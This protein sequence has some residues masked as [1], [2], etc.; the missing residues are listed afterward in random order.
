MLSGIGGKLRSALAAYGTKE[1]VFERVLSAFL[2]VSSVQIIILRKKELDPV[3]GWKEFITSSSLATKL[4]WTVIVFIWLSVIYRLVSKRL[5]GVDGTV[6]TLSSVVFS[7]FLV[8]MSGSFYVGASAAIVAAVLLVYAQR[9]RWRRTV[10]LKD[11]PCGV[12]IFT[13]AAA[14]A[15]FISVT[16][17]A[18]YRSFGTSCFDMGIF[19]Q[20]FNSLK[21][22]FT[23]MTTCER[24]EMM[25]HFQVHSSFIFYLFLPIY[26]LF[27]H[28]ETLLIAQ[29]VFSLA[30]VIPLYLIA[31]RHGFKGVMLISAC[32]I[33]VF[34][35]G[36]IMPCYYQ[37]HE[38]AFLP[39]VLMWLIY[40]ADAANIPLFYIMS[41]LTCSVKEDAPL[42]VICIGI[43]FALENGGSKRKHGI[44]AAVLSGIY[45]VLIMRWL[46][47]NG[48]GSYMTSTRLGLLMAE[49]G[50]GFLGILKNVFLNPGYLISLLLKE[51]TILFFIETMLPMLFMPF[52][53]AK[54]R[55]FILMIP[56][57]VMNLV[58][59]AG[60]GYA[61]DIG[62]QYIFGPSC[63]LIYLALINAEEMGRRQ[64]YLFV[65]AA[66]IITVITGVSMASAK[67]TYTQRYSDY[68]EYYQSTEA[69]IR[70]V[71]KDASVLANTFFLP[72][73]ADRE[74]I[75][76]LS[77]D[78]FVEDESENVSMIGL[79][80]Y[81]Y[82]I[83][84]QGDPLT[85][86]ARPILEAAGWTVFSEQ[87]G[88]FVVI[89][90]S[91]QTEEQ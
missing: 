89:F 5:S 17:V 10:R 78:M 37:F 35:I 58:I 74:E 63:L 31:K 45:F 54:L 42:Y 9:N 68:K 18:N 66:A 49:P 39:T 53:T 12:I 71:P 24:G 26:M 16:T 6:L 86:K 28:G 72:H 41:A 21:E 23:A 88:N 83:L 20:T 46:T 4:I 60:Y 7:L 25:S 76:E 50:D 27:P 75:Y 32:M 48:D 73:A 1:D 22:N 62:F 13:L 69:A 15:I 80:K 81:D 2:T 11:L 55:R 85:A 87:E 67:L 38:N 36:L 84:S 61:A 51:N 3:A 64:K 29:A 57:V 65:T 30:G 91:P 43:F 70:S 19:V 79:E 34:N 8:F 59:G 47:V 40:A 82:C 77:K 90:A 56:Y 44:I 52:M 33:Y 14:V